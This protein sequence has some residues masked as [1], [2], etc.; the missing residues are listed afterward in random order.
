MY[1][2]V[3]RRDACALTRYTSNSVA[4][5]QV[6]SEELHAMESAFLHQA[7]ANQQ[8]VQGLIGL[9]QRDLGN[10]LAASDPG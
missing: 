4:E 6:R 7:E 5:V 10:S 1:L 3:V 8:V 2:E 9:L